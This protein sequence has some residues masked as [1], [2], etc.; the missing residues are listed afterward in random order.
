MLDVSLI[1][2]E[3]YFHGDVLEIGGGTA[4]RRGEYKVST[5]EARKWVFVDISSVPKPHL[6]ADAERLPIVNDTFETVLCLEV[7]E[8]IFDPKTA[9]REMRRVMKPEGK[10]VISLPFM[11]RQDLGNDY[12]RFTRAGAELLLQKAGFKII[13]YENQGGAYSVIAN[14]LKYSIN[15]S[16]GRGRIWLGRFARPILNALSRLDA[17]AELKN[18]LLASFSTGS[19]LVAV[20]NENLHTN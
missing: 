20:P 15:V 13:F 6:R 14:I 18:E 19:I 17:A 8:Y 4:G 10:L 2:I 3:H 12:W 16:K 11:H 9:L 5:D 1:R 7:I